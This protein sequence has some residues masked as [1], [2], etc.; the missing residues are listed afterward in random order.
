MRTEMSLAELVEKVHTAAQGVDFS[1]EI[2]RYEIGPEHRTYLQSLAKPY[3]YRAAL[4]EVLGARTVLEVGTKTGCGILALAKHAERAVTCDL[5]LDQVCDR[6][7]LEGRIEGRELERP[8]DCL[9]IDYAHFDFV[10][11]DIDHEGGMEWRIHQILEASYRGIALFD[12]IEHNDA[13]RDFWA[14]IGNDKLATPWHPPHGAGLVRYPA[15]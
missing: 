8:E 11:I 5:T 12:D 3:R 4:V 1:A 6:R 2:A 13:M 9:T 10:F 7:I 14:K 15:G